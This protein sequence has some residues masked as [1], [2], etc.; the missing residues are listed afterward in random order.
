MTLPSSGAISLSQVNTEL[1]KAANAL[2]SLND[3]DVRTLAGIPSGAIYM[4]NLR[5]KTA[6]TLVYN[7][8]LT[9]GTIS[10]SSPLT[11]GYSALTSP[12][13]GAISP[14]TLTNGVKIASLIQNTSFHQLNL[15]GDHAA[16][17]N[18]N[19]K[20]ISFDGVKCAIQSVAYD[21]KFLVTMVRMAFLSGSAYTKSS[22]AV[23]M[24]I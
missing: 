7:G 9:V 17:V 10:G 8:T 6:E 16:W 20:W 19:I 11:K 3:A 24:G 23:K 2:I 18:A 21:S 13:T 1:G 15:D 4:S 14:G 5:G 22:Y 12:T